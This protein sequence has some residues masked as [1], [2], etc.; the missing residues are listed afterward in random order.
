MK[1]LITSVGSLVGQN[2]LDS[3]ESRRN[4][5]NVIGINSDI[6]NPRNFRCDTVYHTNKTASSNF[7]NDFIT[8][9]EKEN[10]DFILPGRDED[11]LFL[12]EIKIKYPEIFGNKIPFG[13]SFIPRIMLDKHKSFL[14]CKEN[15]LPFADTFLYKNKNSIEGLN[16]FIEKHN[17]PLVVKP[18]EGFGSQGVY[19]VLN[20]GQ[21][22]ELIKDDDVLF[23]EF[24]GD[25][26]EIFK[27]KNVFK[28]GI[29]LFFQMPEEKHYA[30]Q[31][32][33]HPDGSISE[34]FFTI[35]TMVFG[36]NE[37]VEQIPSY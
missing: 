27:Y 7:E 29:P 2:I 16:T 3:I 26:E 24:L 12:S 4:I 35:N 36:R 8:I 22:K 28:K 13:N 37:Y 18:R 1:L 21:V 5:I 10:P 31:A 11:C 20:E 14:F 23:Q 32:V 15:Q 17:Y 6:K 25:P 9:I 33:I 34:I 30:S 19:F